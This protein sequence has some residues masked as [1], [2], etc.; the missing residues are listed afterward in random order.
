MARIRNRKGNRQPCVA[1]K[2]IAVMT[3]NGRIEG[4]VVDASET[5]LGLLLPA[6]SGVKSKQKIRVVY[7]RQ[8]Q[9]ARVVRVEESPEGD[10]LGIILDGR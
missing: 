6:G 1:D 5:G 2:T 8:M 3:P 9:M 4:E 7:R 10:R